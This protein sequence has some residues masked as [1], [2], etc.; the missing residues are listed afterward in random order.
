MR[1]SIGQHTATCGKL[2]FPIET[3]FQVQSSVV[4]VASMQRLD[5]SDR[6]FL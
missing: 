3:D 1:L 5:A 6:S 2:R 4:E